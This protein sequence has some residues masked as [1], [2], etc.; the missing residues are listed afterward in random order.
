[1]L[2]IV[3]DVRPLPSVP[4]APGAL[5]VIGHA[6][7]FLRDPL[8]FLM[9]LPADSGLVSIGLGP[10][11]MVLVRDADL[12]RQVLLDDR[13]F[14]KGGVLFERARD[15]IGDNLVTVRHA[16]HRGERRLHQPAFHPSR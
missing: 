11:S 16:R 8:G 2:E 1:M 3:K 6:H 5:P 10:I 14:D 4:L 15:V 13:V 12:T 9:S 7:R